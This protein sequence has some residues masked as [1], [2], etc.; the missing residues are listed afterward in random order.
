MEHIAVSEAKKLG[1]PMVAVIDTD[2]DPDVVDSLIPGNDDTIRSGAPAGAAYAILDAVIEGKHIACSSSDC[3]RSVDDDRRVAAE[4]A[5]A[6]RQALI[7]SPRRG[8]WQAQRTPPVLPP[9]PPATSAPDAPAAGP[10]S[11]GG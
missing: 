3:G 7:E 10:A 4:Q 5:G 11:S 9:P 1:I 8:P 6:R 2:S